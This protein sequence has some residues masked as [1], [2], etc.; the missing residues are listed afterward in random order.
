MSRTLR[1]PPLLAYGSLRAPLALLELPL[2]VLLPAFYSERIGMELALIGAILF[3]TRLLDA[4]LDPAIGVMLDRSSRRLTLRGW[5]LATLPLLI[6]GYAALFY[7]PDGVVP[8]VWLA[9]S[10]ML[11]YLAYSLISIAYQT[12]GA[13]LGDSATER[14]RITATREA[15]GLAGVLV[16]ASFL[17]A[18]QTGR[19]VLL[20]VGAAVISALVLRRAPA[21]SAW[22]K[23]VL[24][25]GEAPARPA[26][27]FAVR[28]TWRTVL[29]LRPFRWLL[30]VFVINGIATAIPATLVLFFV[31]DVLGAADRAPLFLVVYFLAGA[32]GM[33]IWVKVA[34]RLGLT[35]TWLLGMSFAVAAFVWTL[36]LGPGDV[37]PFLFVCVMTGLA[38][39]ADLAI[40]PAMLANVL[41]RR[42]RDDNERGEA[43][44]FG[45]WNL[46]TKFN[47]AVAAGVALPLLG[48]LG[49]EPGQ[50][51]GDT[52]ALSMTYAALPCLLKLAAG[53]LLLLA[54][55]PADEEPLT[56]SDPE[57]PVAPPSGVPDPLTNASFR[58]PS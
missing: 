15:F 13:Q 49:Y 44:F 28:E 31:A 53:C 54:P 56:L 52:V 10:S 33:P 41:A 37:V 38:L 6:I 18:D 36:G 39:G 50:A 48:W 21:P 29:G 42:S 27:L 2:F 51:V 47:L 32:V 19:L 8:A 43:T 7:P 25:A 24:P 3:A 14:V 5:I 17:T 30:A 57:G 4:V 46:A 1:W 23:A 55:M 20:F 11:V 26:R 16:S 34:A 40:P 35:F 9:A 45:V 12:W 22:Q 58:E